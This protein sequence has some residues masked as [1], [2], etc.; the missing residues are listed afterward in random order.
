MANTR[1]DLLVEQGSDEKF[2]NTMGS[3]VNFIH[4]L[5]NTPKLPERSL[6]RKVCHLENHNV[7]GFF[8]L[9]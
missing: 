3:F 5:S 6:A 4:V 1:H 9:S 2:R 8:G 7:F